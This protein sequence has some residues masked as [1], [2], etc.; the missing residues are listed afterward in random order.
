MQLII[1]IIS[2]HITPA[3]EFNAAL[4]PPL[5]FS[6]VWCGLKKSACYDQKQ[7]YIY[8]LWLYILNLHVWECVSFPGLSQ[9]QQDLKVNL[10]TQLCQCRDWGV[11]GITPSAPKLGTDMGI[12][13]GDHTLTLARTKRE[14]QENNRKELANCLYL[15]ELELVIKQPLLIRSLY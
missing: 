4:F 3:S 11:T 2:F 8:A 12:S 14:W 13:K 5:Q 15:N 7:C 10:K 9:L 6:P 1:L